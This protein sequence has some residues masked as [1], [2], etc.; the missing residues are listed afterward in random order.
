MESISKQQQQYKYI[1][2]IKATRIEA[3]S[4]EELAKEL[5]VSIP[6]VLSLVKKENNVK[7]LL[8]NF[9]EV[10]REKKIKKEPALRVKKSKK[11][12]CNQK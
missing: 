12:M 11:T 3:N 8:K 2:V 4:L 1:A 5:K 6:T 10:T 7:T 9:I